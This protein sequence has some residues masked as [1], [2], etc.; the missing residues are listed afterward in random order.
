MAEQD[1][2]FFAP[3]T[4]SIKVLPAG[5]WRQEGGPKSLAGWAL[6][7]V[8]NQMKRPLSREVESLTQLNLANTRDQGQH[9]RVGTGLRPQHTDYLGPPLSHR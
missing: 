9:D 8:P 1:P 3:T 7:L 2:S 5:L 4:P 6:D